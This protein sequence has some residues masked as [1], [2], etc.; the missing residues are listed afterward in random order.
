MGIVV[1]VQVDIVVKELQPHLV[2]Q[3][4]AKVQSGHLAHGQNALL[5]VVVD[6]KR[7]ILGSAVRSV[8]STCIIKY[9]KN[10]KSL[11]ST[12]NHGSSF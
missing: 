4:K 3:M 12:T 1:S 11:P 6:K 5:V 7:G 9:K 8:V 10:N 2:L